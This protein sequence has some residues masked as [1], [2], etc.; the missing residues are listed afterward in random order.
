M[1]LLKIEMMGLVFN[2][3]W[4]NH[5]L[6]GQLYLCRFISSFIRAYFINESG[7]VVAKAT[8]DKF[9]NTRGKILN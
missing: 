2:T 6:S 4:E 7:T 5:Q 8:V 9:C 1:D 3:I